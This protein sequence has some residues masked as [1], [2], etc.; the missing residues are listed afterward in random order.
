[1]AAPAWETHIALAVSVAGFALA[2]VT[3]WSDRRRLKALDLHELSRALSRLEKA[4]VDHLRATAHQHPTES[5]VRE[6]SN[7]ARDLLPRV[8]WEDVRR[9][10][11]RAIEACGRVSTPGVREERIE[12]RDEIRTGIET[13]MDA[14]R[15]VIDDR[16]EALMSRRRLLRDR[17][18]AAS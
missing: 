10:A 6:L 4:A 16:V 18:S 3:M 15:G 9:A 17:R 8:G 1:M 2:A 11:E 14:A 7:A 12:K 5:D 13:A